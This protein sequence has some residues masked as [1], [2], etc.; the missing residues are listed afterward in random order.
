MR[1]VSKTKIKIHFYKLC[2]YTLS[3]RYFDL[4]SKQVAQ[5]QFT[6]KC[7]WYLPCNNK[8]WLISTFEIDRD[9]QSFSIY[10]W[11]YTEFF[12]QYT[13]IWLCILNLC[14]LHLNCSSLFKAIIYLQNKFK[15]GFN[16]FYLLVSKFSILHNVLF[17]SYFGISWLLAFRCI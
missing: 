13:L 12:L 3:H 4:Q 8:V 7:L 9:R 1:S 6:N 17:T 10:F 14:V 11:I 15:M 5:E 2:W 16:L